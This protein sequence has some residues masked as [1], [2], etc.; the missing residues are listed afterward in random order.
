MFARGPNIYST[1][2][3]ICKFDDY[4]E[5]TN[6][7]DYLSPWHNIVMVIVVFGLTLTNDQGQ[8]PCGSFVWCGFNVSV[9]ILFLSSSR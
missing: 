2:E 5:T 7:T 4:A 9:L 6:C 8:C 3:L 1:L